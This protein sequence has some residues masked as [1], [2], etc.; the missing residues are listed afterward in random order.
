MPLSLTHWAGGKGRQLGDLLPLI[1]LTRI[2]VE[3]FGGGAAV[4][5]NRPRSEIEVYND[6][7]GELVNLFQVMRD[8]ELCK[9]FRR[10][11][12]LVP[13][14]RSEFERSL[15][16]SAED[17][18]VSRAIQFYTVLNQSVS[19][20]RLAGPGDW[21]R[22]RT[23]NNAERWYERQHSLVAIHQ[24]VKGIQVEAR[25]ALDILKE[26][27]TDDT[28]FYCDPPYILETRGR[29]RYYAIEPGDDYHER[30]VDILLGVS[31]CVVLS[32]YNHPIYFRL[33]D[34]GWWTD[35]YRQTTT[36]DIEDSKRGQTKDRIE[37]VWRNR[38]AA[39]WAMKRPL[40]L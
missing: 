15:G 24:R 12:A 33:T 20:K 2:Y 10:R 35:S 29:N 38:K 1:P 4:L 13:Y 27:D 7:D 14:S 5:L 17:D 16:F 8:D 9:T 19:G 22:N 21:S 32:G 18:P 23:V 28:T 36:M 39:D 6:L 26:W 34:A 30:L 11:L 3:P 40:F 31:G 37:I 25:D